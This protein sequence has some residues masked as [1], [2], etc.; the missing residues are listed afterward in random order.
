MSEV[1]PAGV[2]STFASGLDNPTGL[3]FDAAG[4]LY[5]ANDSTGTVS[6]VTPAGV[7]STF[8][9]GF[10]GPDGLAFDAGNLY[11]ANSGNTVS[12]GQRNRDRAVHARRDG[13]VGHRLQR[14]HGQ[15]ADVRDRADHRHPS[16]ARCSP[17]PAP[18]RR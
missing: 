15:S 1:T 8:A 2:V 5:V 17:T 7:V 3:A 13:G 9:S 11:V 14:R 6:E 16:P 10:S 4:N 12:E 18:A